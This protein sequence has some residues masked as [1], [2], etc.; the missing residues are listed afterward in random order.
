M[1][2]TDDNG[3]LP[4]SK[5]GDYSYAATVTCG[6]GDIYASFTSN[7]ATLFPE[8]D[9]LPAT[10]TGYLDGSHDPLPEHF[11]SEMGFTGANPTY[12]QQDTSCYSLASASVNTGKCSAT[13][14][15]S[16]VPVWVTLDN[17][18]SSV[19]S[20]F[21]VTVPRHVVRHDLHGQRARQPEQAHRNLGHRWRDCRC[22]SSTTSARPLC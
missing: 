10:T 6:Q 7:D 5:S 2:G 4:I 1:V 19:S 15:T 20:T 9:G 14:G 18:S 17:S 22:P 3:N 13:T 16:L 12:V 21:E 11:L 8:N